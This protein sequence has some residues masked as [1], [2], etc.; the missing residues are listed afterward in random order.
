[1]FDKIDII[2]NH[3]T[4]ELEF[5]KNELNKLIVIG[6][7]GEKKQSMETQTFI[8]I[9]KIKFTTVWKKVSRIVTSKNPLLKS[10]IFPNHTRA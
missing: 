10:M 7:R 5:R 6:Y 2:R 9:S 3:Q 1:M 8:S 4:I